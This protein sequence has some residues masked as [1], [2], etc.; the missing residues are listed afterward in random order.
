MNRVDLVLLEKFLASLVPDEAANALN[1]AFDQFNKFPFPMAQNCMF[2]M[3]Q[4]FENENLELRI[5]G[6]NCIVAGIFLA[7]LSQD[8]ETK[9]I[10]T[11][12]LDSHAKAKGENVVSFMQKK[13]GRDRT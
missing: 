4:M 7:S 1:S 5:C 13:A 3:K 11:G 12:W 9:A 6:V 2:T 8:D 10:F